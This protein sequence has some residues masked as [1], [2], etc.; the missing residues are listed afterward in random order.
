MLKITGETPISHTGRN[1]THFECQRADLRSDVIVTF[2]WKISPSQ[3]MEDA[4]EFGAWHALNIHAHLNGFSGY[5][6]VRYVFPG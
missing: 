3:M 4:T 1:G 2:S 6:T 5:D